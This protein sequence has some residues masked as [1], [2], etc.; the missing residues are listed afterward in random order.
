MLI[1]LV[2]RHATEAQRETERYAAWS[3]AIRRFREDPERRDVRAYLEHVPAEQ[4]EGALHDLVAER[5][6]LA[7]REGRGPL[8]ESF[9][10]DAIT[11]DLVEDEFLARYQQPHGDAPEL[12][13]YVRRFPEV[14]KILERR[15]LEGGRIVKL[16]KIGVGAMGEVWEAYDRRRRELVALKTSKIRLVVSGLEHPGI[17]AVYEVLGDG[18]GL[19]RLARGRTLAER[20]GESGRDL[21]SSF[22]SA[23]EAVAYAHARGVVHGDLK[24]GNIIVDDSGAAVVIDWGGGARTPEYMAPEQADGPASA[25]SD[26]FA[27]GK[28]LFEILAGRPSRAWGRVCAKASASDP[29]A[30]Y[31]DASEL[32]AEVRRCVESRGWRWFLRWL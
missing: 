25:R 5:L 12:E 30:R 19:M 32:L 14:W 22:V 29:A 26:V 4:R 10:L 8:L 18:S 28:V 9:Q 23:C 27:L 16:R 31:R 2:A 24:P 20:M 1:P 21:L 7:W 17:A 6:R 3:A 13:E 11:A 15:V